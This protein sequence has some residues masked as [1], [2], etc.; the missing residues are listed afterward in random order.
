MTPFQR[1][2]L[3]DGHPQTALW[4]RWS[5]LSVTPRSPVG[6]T[7]INLLYD[8][9]MNDSDAPGTI[10]LGSGAYMKFDE[11]RPTR[12]VCDSILI[13]SGATLWAG[14]STHPYT[15]QAQIDICGDVPGTAVRGAQ[16]VVNTATAN[17][18]GSNDNFGQNR[19]IIVSPG[20]AM[21]MAG[22][23]APIVRRMS[24]A[25]SSGSTITVDVPVTAPAGATV[26]VTPD[27]FYNA[28]KRTETRTLLVAAVNSTTLTLSSPL[29][30]AR[31]GQIQ[32]PTD[33]GL[34]LTP[35]TFSLRTPA[36]P[37]GM[38]AEVGQDSVI[39]YCRAVVVIYKQNISIN[40][41][42]LAGHTNLANGDG[43]HTMQM[44][45]TS[46]MY[47]KNLT[48]TNYGQRGLTGRYGFHVHIPSYNSSGV[49]KNDGSVIGNLNPAFTGGPYHCN[50]GPDE[51]H[52]EGIVGVNGFNRMGV[53]HACRGV[54]FDS[55]IAKDAKGHAFF[56]E[57]GAEEE[58]TINN[59]ISIG[60]S[61]P[62]TGNRIQVHDITPAGFWFANPF[63]T[64]TNNQ[65]VDTPSAPWINAMSFGMVATQVDSQ[66]GCYGFASNVPISPGFGRNGVFTNNNGLCYGSPAQSSPGQTDQAG[67]GGD[68]N[69]IQTTSNG[70]ADQGGNRTNVVSNA[71]PTLMTA[72]HL[73]KGMAYVNAIGCPM[74][75]YWQQTDQLNTMWTGV[76]Y[77][78]QPSSI[79][80]PIV[81]YES[82]N[83]ESNYLRTNNIF[84]CGW[85]SYHGT[86]PTQY[87][88]VYNF[89]GAI[90]STVGANHGAVQKVCAQES[91]DNYLDPLEIY[92]IANAGWCLYN[93]E[94]MWMTPPSHLTQS[95]TTYDFI[96]GLANPGPKY[97]NYDPSDPN[98]PHAWTFGILFDRFG[99]MSQ[100]PSTAGI[101]NS[102]LV[103]NVP[104]FTYGLTTTALEKNPQ[105]VA[106][107]H[108]FM[109]A[110]TYD[111]ADDHG[112]QFIGDSPGRRASRNVYQRVDSSGNDIAG[113]IWD[114]PDIGA[115]VV[116]F[117]H[118]TCPVN[119]FVRLSWPNKTKP[120]AILRVQIQWIANGTYD[121][122]PYSNPNQNAATDGAS[123]GFDWGSTTAPTVKDPGGSA[124]PVA[125]SWA[126]F[127]SKT[128]GGWQWWDATNKRIWTRIPTYQFNFNI[129]INP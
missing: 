94:G 40:G 63:N 53:L 60:H 51:S 72:V 124:Y 89:T 79:F 22:T 31:F 113:A 52:F 80:G 102:F 101:P 12:L 66:H 98:V 3:V 14:D 61:D 32:Y 109:G 27:G 91:W 1:A 120:T 125:T 49:P 25:Y 54:V 20:G 93:S 104:Y 47:L 83:H 71:V 5:S 64:H 30:F 99:T 41:Y 82:L 100:G 97:V 2:L 10:T 55:C 121:P 35:G 70:L 105:S 37:T 76:T 7:N 118:G 6:F 19:G 87:P 74:Y 96:T 111:D 26:M 44:G 103:F 114:M 129:T 4:V 43:V 112:P 122:Y 38:R 50:Y 73:H 11:S 115:G 117:H 39:N 33:S 9:Q 34:S 8:V 17:D 77:N 57:T 28:S 86:L 59:C 48:M 15:A 119:G 116:G 24:V 36:N 21:Y 46:R 23:S 81:A 56:E 110:I 92:S 16:Y 29:G 127:A 65:A 42:D 90:Y 67:N 13:N 88:S 75:M 78:A 84:A 126:D 108:P 69:K 18:G 107:T 123:W 95:V 62:G 106:T 58:N 45:L 85:T 128:S 68:I